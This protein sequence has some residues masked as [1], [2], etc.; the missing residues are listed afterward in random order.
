MNKAHKLITCASYGGTGSSVVTDLLKEFD[1]V[2]SMGNFEF[3]F[4]YEINGISDLEHYVVDD[5]HRLKTDEGI[6]RFQQYI[7]SLSRGFNNYTQYF[8]H[9]FEKLSKEYI[10]SLVDVEWEG[11]WHQH[12]YRNKIKSI[13][14]Y[15]PSVIKLFMFRVIGQKISKKRSTEYTPTF[16]RTPMKLSIGKDKFIKETQNYTSSL[17]DLLDKD[18]Q[19]EYIALDQLVPPTNLQRYTRY[20]KDLK[21][22]VVDRDPRD[23]F[24]LNK[25]YWN[26]GWIPTQNVEV[27]IK[28]FKLLRADENRDKEDNTNIMRIRFEDF[29]YNYDE[30]LSK[31][32][33]FM[34]VDCNLHTQRKKYFNP[35][36]SKKNCQLWNKHPG[37][38]K[39]MNQ[40]LEELKEYCYEI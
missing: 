15:G 4:A 12:I 9:E 38:E 13:Y 32:T 27:F 29:I 24:L 21:V 30:T 14:M 1:N 16:R 19:F 28:W 20:F 6:Y 34:E 8:G 17:I 26:E 35:E 3:T 31:I 39:E 5:Y 2:K 11:F 33:K 23:L 7:K 22:I 36:I 25:L 10:E 40:I 37:Y 18:N